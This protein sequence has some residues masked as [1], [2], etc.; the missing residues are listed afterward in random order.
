MAPSGR[1][2]VY[3]VPVP[4]ETSRNSSIVLPSSSR[5]FLAPFACSSISDLIGSPSGVLT[6]SPSK[7]ALNDSLYPC[8]ARVIFWVP[9]SFSSLRICS[10]G[11][12]EVDKN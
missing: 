10:S 6:S 12:S 5:S 8:P 4:I 1:T 2:N 11:F 3:D 7:S 9:A